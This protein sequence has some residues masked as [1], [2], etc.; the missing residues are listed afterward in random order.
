MVHASRRERERG[1][2]D[3]TR[4]RSTRPGNE[5]VVVAAG[6]AAG[7][8]HRVRLARAGLP[9]RHDGGVDAAVAHVVERGRGTRARVA[10]ARARRTASKARRRRRAARG[11]GEGG[12]GDDVDLRASTRASTG[13]AAPAST[14]DGRTRHTTRVSP[15]PLIARAGV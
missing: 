10:V 7:A 1:G 11:G 4:V 15:E 12:G 9:V 6:A 13:D 2:K 5:T 14:R 3:E 8:L